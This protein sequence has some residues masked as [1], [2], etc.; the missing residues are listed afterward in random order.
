M[1]GHLPK[2]ED[3]PNFLQTC[4]EFV[5]RYTGGFYTQSSGGMSGILKGHPREFL[6][7]LFS[8][9]LSK[10]K[11]VEIHGNMREEGNHFAVAKPYLLKKTLVASYFFGLLH[12]NAVGMCISG[13]T[14]VRS[15]N[16]LY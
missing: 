14:K 9:Y 7:L 16:F 2:W 5:I 11:S 10:K 1:E 8:L 13:Y 4:Y 3:K 15:N 12:P 6:K